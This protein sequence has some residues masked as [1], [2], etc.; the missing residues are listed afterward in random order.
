MC[1]YV[2]TL[3][4]AGACGLCLRGEYIS[5]LPVEIKRL[6]TES[7]LP[8]IMVSARIP[9]ADIIREITELVIL[10]QK[11]ELLHNQIHVLISGNLDAASKE[12]IIKGF[13]PYFQNSGAAV[14]IVA[15]DPRQLHHHEKDITNIFNR[16][17]LS[18]GAPFEN[19][20]L[21][22]VGASNRPGT[23]MKQLIDYYI[24][25]VQKIVPDVCIG[26]SKLAL[27][28]A[29]CDYAIRQAMTVARAN[30]S[31]ITGKRVTYYDELGIL[32]FLLIL[33][34]NQDAIDFVDEIITPLVDYDNK[35]NAELLPT[36]ESFLAHKHD[37]KETANAMY[38]H[39]NTVRYRLEKA[40]NLIGEEQSMDVFLESFTLAY[41][42][43]KLKAYQGDH[44]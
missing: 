32:K 6:C 14:Y 9:Y 17:I 39:V 22:L 15:D 29:D 26:I 30:A 43:Y 28:A 38:V 34:K 12:Y 35:H 33:S 31:N 11:D 44:A 4:D 10:D 27:A 19:G 13:N 37:P 21:G 8:V 7:R 20:I 25:E 23:G 36:L 5:D 1:A 24:G 41:K 3:T 18:F 16:G 40:K 2:K 42:L